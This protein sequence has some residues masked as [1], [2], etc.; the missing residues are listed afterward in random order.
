MLAGVSLP[1]YVY[2]NIPT[3]SSHRQSI[4]SQGMEVSRSVTW[5][6]H[7]LDVDDLISQYIRFDSEYHLCKRYPFMELG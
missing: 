6:S 2:S 3:L 1:K 5:S 4:Y 7:D